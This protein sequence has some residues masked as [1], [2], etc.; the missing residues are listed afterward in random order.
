MS[1]QPQG[2]Q[3]REF[4][5]VGKEGRTVL[6]NADGTMIIENFNEKKGY[7]LVVNTLD[8]SD[9]KCYLIKGEEVSVEDAVLLSKGLLAKEDGQNP[10]WVVRESDFEAEPDFIR[11]EVLS[12]AEQAGTLDRMQGYKEVIECHDFELNRHS[13]NE[14]F[15]EIKN[16]L[17]ANRGFA[18]SAEPITKLGYEYDEDRSIEY[19]GKP[20][21]VY[22]DGK[23]L[24]LQDILDMEGRDFE[25]PH[26]QVKEHSLETLDR[27][28]DPNIER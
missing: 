11:E 3:M 2:Y 9:G 23:I 17:D 14:Q 21:S 20:L 19:T 18:E 28:P 24:T 26:M 13:M 15:K 22:E 8:E 27:L 12:I 16:E 5:N 1:G 25:L 7:D 4:E 6:F 10:K